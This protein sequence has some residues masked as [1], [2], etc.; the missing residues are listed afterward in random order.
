MAKKTDHKKMWKA[1]RKK[2]IDAE[3]R[4]GVLQEIMR[5]KKKGKTNV[6]KD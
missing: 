6:K 2:R 5:V 3:N 1:E 4:L